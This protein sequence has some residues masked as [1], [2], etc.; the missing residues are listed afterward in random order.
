MP[1]LA[2]IMPAVAVA[3]AATGIAVGA[4]DKGISS[5]S[6]TFNTTAVAAQTKTRTCTGAD[7]PYQLIHAVYAGTGGGLL[8]NTNV[9]LRFNATINTQ[10]DL[11]L[12]KGTLT[13]RATPGNALKAK[14]HFTAVLDGTSV[15]G[16]LNGRAHDAKA[17]LLANFSAT[18]GSNTLNG[19]LGGGSAA[20]TAILYGG[21][22]CAKVT[23]AQANTQSQI[24]HGKGKGKQKGPKP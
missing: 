21:T 23:N 16:F 20:N 17:T 5:T 1:K 4:K 15:S 12:L 3:L 6:A 10:E 19:Q 18:L 8:A 9:Q 7:G 2:W 13:A 11:G 14:T 24:Q 22:G